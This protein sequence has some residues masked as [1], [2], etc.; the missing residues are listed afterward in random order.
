MHLSLTLASLASFALATVS[1]QHPE[2]GSFEQSIGLEGAL[3]LQNIEDGVLVDQ[4]GT[5][6]NMADAQVYAD[7]F[8]PDNFTVSSDGNV[9][10]IRTGETFSAA[11]WR[12]TY[13][14]GTVLQIVKDED[15]EVSY[16]EIRHSQP[17]FDTFFVPSEELSN[18]CQAMLSFT[19]NHLDEFSLQSSYVFGEAPSL[20]SD[21]LRGRNLLPK[22][23]YRRGDGTSSECTYFKVVRV[24]LLY[25][26]DFCKYYGSSTAAR[27]RI[28]A[29][30]ASASLYYERDLC[31][32]LQL[33]YLGS[34]DGCAGPSQTFKNFR[35]DAACGT[36]SSNFLSDFSAWI[37]SR[38]SAMGINSNSLV[39]L[40]TG[41]PPNNMLGCAWRGTLCSSAWSYGVE[42]P[43]FNQNNIV[44]QSIVMAHE[45]GVR[46][47]DC[48]RFHGL[49]RSR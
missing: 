47:L 14:N 29:V 4:F 34:P 21:R 28:M 19:L 39:H 36:Q 16:A 22:F 30:F 8:S 20:P 41:Y 44:T 2:F 1:G 25:D 45:I 40:L 37:R 46:M 31:V 11:V 9:T 38:R 10:D 48:A 23:V 7:L 42:Y 24:A 32:K 13:S 6:Y 3:G 27:N 17:E 18:D 35:R 15:G 26:G 12:A 5:E 49:G 33:T 43:A